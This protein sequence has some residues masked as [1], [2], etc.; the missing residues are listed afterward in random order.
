MEQRGT[1][2]SAEKKNH[3]GSS[4]SA[5]TV[6]YLYVQHATRDHEQ[7]SNKTVFLEEEACYQKTGAQWTTV[8][9]RV[10]GIHRRTDNLQERA[11]RM[12]FQGHV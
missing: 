6:N 3:R 11:I 8:A 5:N 4:Y 2:A 1:G 10:T 7:R 9:E 12:S